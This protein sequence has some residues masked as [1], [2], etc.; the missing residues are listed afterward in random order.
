M[1]GTDSSQILLLTLAVP[2]LIAAQVG[3]LSVRNRVRRR[4]HASPST[5]P[6]LE[7]V[8]RNALEAVFAEGA[9]HFDE[10]LEGASFRAYLVDRA[11]DVADRAESRVELT[12][13]ERDVLRRA[14]VDAVL[15]S[16]DLDDADR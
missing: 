7:T 10:S 8:V 13:T 9:A 15:E 16:F 12:R 1:F 5:G 4:L 14:L 11:N 6:D 2:L 3:L